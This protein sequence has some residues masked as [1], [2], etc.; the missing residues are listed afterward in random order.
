MR[1]AKNYTE[2]RYRIDMI[3]FHEN[4][5]D[6]CFDTVYGQQRLLA[7]TMLILCMDMDA[8]FPLLELNSFSNS[9]SRRNLIARHTR[10]LDWAV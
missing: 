10:V 7:L 8:S 6:A 9:E 4:D 5:E 2:F 3:I 1:S